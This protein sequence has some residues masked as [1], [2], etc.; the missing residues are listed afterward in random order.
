MSKKLTVLPVIH[1]FGCY[2]YVPDLNLYHSFISYFN[3]LSDKQ[4]KKHTFQDR[5]GRK[6][7]FWSKPGGFYN[8]KTNQLAFEYAIHWEDPTG[9]SKCYML[10]KPLF[11]KGT[12]TKTGKETNLPDVGTNIEVRSSYFS[13]DDILKV[14]DDV[15]DEI[16]ASRFKSLVDFSKSH[17]FQMARHIRYHEQYETDVVNMLKAIKDESAIRGDYDLVEKR[18]SSFYDMY[19]I[20]IP[21]LD[22]CGIDHDYIH[23]V[24][25]YRITDFLQ[26]DTSD[27]L[28]H[29]KLEV[30]LNPIEHKR[31]HGSNPTLNEYDYIKRDLDKVLACL[32]NFVFPYSHDQYVS[33][34]YFD[35]TRTYI[36]R[37][38]LPSWN[39]EQDTNK[40]SAP[41]L[42]NHDN[43]L[44]FL[45]YIAFNRNGFAEFQ[46][47]VERTEIP[48]RSCWRYL[49]YYKSIGILDSIREKCTYVFFKKQSLWYNIKDS[50]KN[51]ANYLKFGFKNVW[52]YMMYDSDK[53]RPYHE[54]DKN[55]TP[56]YKHRNDTIFVDNQK[57]YDR[58]MKELKAH[59]I[60]QMVVL[61]NLTRL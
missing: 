35:G 40:D 12:K 7:K 44:K 43:K 30:F 15:L 34:D 29:P 23:S 13:I 49:N 50:L 25:S 5:Y 32:L 24:K 1:E 52:G 33:D 42:P 3:Q 39:Y 11:G 38:N 41:E 28:R 14:F 46:D 10:F 48:E 54:R 16:D 18:R 55:L 47:I 37:H 20:D 56:A 60:Q 21:S 27:P 61:T 51:L 2:L 9:A 8:P 6:F 59:N 26:R 58:I 45:A 53:V 19:K 36:I 31:V 57:D 4:K 17:I 22:V